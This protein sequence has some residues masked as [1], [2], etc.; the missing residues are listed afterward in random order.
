MQSWNRAISTTCVL[1]N[2][3]QESCSH[4]FFGCR[5][6]GQVWRQLVGGLLLANYTADWNTLKMLLSN[7]GLNLTKTSIFRYAL[8]ATMH[9]V[10]RER[11]AR[12]H[13]EQPRD[14]NCLVKFVDKTMR[15]ELLSVKGKGQQYL[16]EGLITWF[17]VQKTNGGVG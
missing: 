3:D 15:L 17:G 13:G 6:S 9:S 5:Y 1:C 16:E 7:P 14:V 4:L 8:Q 11:N 10:W 12:R 2:E